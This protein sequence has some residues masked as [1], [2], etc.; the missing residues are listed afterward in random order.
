MPPASKYLHCPICRFAAID[1][2]TGVHHADCIR[3]GDYTIS[4]EASA[5][6]E[7][8][9]FDRRQA[10]NVCGYLRENQGMMIMESSLPF[11]RALRSPS[12]AERATKLLAWLARKNNVIGQE[13]RLLSLRN[14]GQIL[15]RASEIDA[16]DD[17]T[18]KQFRELL[19]PFAISW[20]DEP[21]EL[22][23][24]L[25]TYLAAEE[26][27]ITTDARGPWLS[28]VITSRGWKHLYDLPAGTGSV[29]FVAMWFA[30][31]MNAAWEQSFHPAITDAGYKALRIDKEEHNNKIDDEILASIRASKFVVA[32]FTEQRGG[33]YYEAGFAQGLG[34]P[35]IWTIREDHL[36]NVHFDT[37]QF[38]HIAWNLSAL[39][40]FKL[41]L[42]RRIEASFGRGPKA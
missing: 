4:S 20:S 11:L 15:A 3:C 32:D 42:Q 16:M 18:A 25:R 23:F 39:P 6:L 2:Y 1:N 35:V 21:T 12:V 31:E 24:L 26:Q 17:T 29:G 7:E 19:D 36:P 37:R 27:F 22:D 28:I 33:V 14:Y 9:P 34:K 13:I 41:A 5:I 10:A 8:V 40:D 30:P 38:N